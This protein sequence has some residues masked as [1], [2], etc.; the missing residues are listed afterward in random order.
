MKRKITDAEIWDG[1]V[2]ESDVGFIPL[3][4]L[5]DA[6]EAVSKLRV[7]LSDES[8]P[9]CLYP[10][11]HSDDALSH[12]AE[13]R[14]LSLNKSHS[15]QELGPLKEIASDDGDGSYVIQ[16][17]PDLERVMIQT[18][19]PSPRGGSQVPGHKWPW[20]IKD[21]PPHPVPISRAS[22]GHF[23]CS[24]HDR[25]RNALASADNLEVPDFRGKSLLED[26]QPPPGLECF[27]ERLF[28]LAYR[29]LLFRISQLRGSEQAAGQTL[30]ERSDAGNRFAV[31]MTLRVLDDL[32]DRLIKLYRIKNG[33]DRRILGD[34]SA[35][36]LVHHVVRFRPSIRYVC[37]EYGPIDI[38]TGRRVEA[39]WMSVNIL[40]LGSETWLIV[41]HPCQRRSVEIGIEQ[42]VRRIST[43]DQMQR[44]QQDLRMMRTCINL[45]VSPSEAE[46]LSPGERSSTSRSMA[47]AVFEEPLKEGLE[48][49]RSSKASNGLI[50]RIESRLRSGA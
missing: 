14:A 11:G 17:F 19:G 12:P 41:S 5:S 44:R 21:I 18:K 27:I 13:C 29:T 50:T 43:P 15:I 7:P 2:N 42:E 4:Q 30:L 20:E 40:A 33:F 3:S 10:V 16:F 38:R 9:K 32:S 47:E 25:D 49:L 31:R 8:S 26:R 28:F 34:S 24:F 23:A 37:A 39:V 35:L 1:I 45:Y 48:I 6:V 22:V 36:H 46:F